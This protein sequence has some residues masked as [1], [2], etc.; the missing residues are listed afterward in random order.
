MTNCVASNGVSLKKTLHVVAISHIIN[1]ILHIRQ[2][3][4]R[5]N[6]TTSCALDSRKF[7]AYDQ[8]LMTEWHAS[9]GGRS[10]MIYWH[11]DTHSTCIY[12]QLR[13]CSKFQMDYFY[14]HLDICAL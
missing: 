3:A 7:G 12:S 8:N 9:D 10:V 2:T 14:L 5:G 11:V 6:T 1:R 4:I 13:R